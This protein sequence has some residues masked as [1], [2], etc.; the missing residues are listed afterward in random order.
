VSILTSAVRVY[1]I[2]DLVIEKSKSRSG[3]HALTSIVYIYSRRSGLT[4]YTASLISE[5][6]AK[7]TYA[8]GEAKRIKIKVEH[9]DFVIYAR[10]VKNL[11]KAVKGLIMILNHKGELLYR[12]KYNN[13]FVVK[14]F[15]NPTYAWLVRLFL[16]SLKIPY[17]STRLGDE[18]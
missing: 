14:S 18:K 12:A 10:F 3:K 16:D 6:P 13:G 4:P 5:E 8:K 9:G 1:E 11:K 7:P 2:S 15:G 17:T